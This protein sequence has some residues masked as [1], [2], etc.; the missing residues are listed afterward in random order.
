MTLFKPY[1]IEKSALDALA[2]KEGQ[3][4]F[5]TDTKEIYLDKNDTERILLGVED[6][7]GKLELKADKS[8]LDEIKISSSSEP[9]D[10][11][12]S[13]TVIAPIKDIKVKGN[14]AQEEQDFNFVS[15]NYNINIQSK[16]LLKI[17]TAINKTTHGITVSL[18]E[19]GGIKINGTVTSAF[20][21]DLALNLQL[22]GIY[23][24]S[25]YS[26]GFLSDNNACEFL[27]YN[28]ENISKLRAPGYRNQI[29]TKT[30]E[31]N[32]IINRFSI[33]FKQ[34][35]YLDAVF[36]FQLEKGEKATAFSKPVNGKQ[37]YQLN[38]KNIELNKIGDYSDYIYKKENKWIKHQVIKR[39]ILNSTAD[40]KLREE[41]GLI[42]TID[43]DINTFSLS[44]WFS[45]KYN[46]KN[47][48]VL[49]NCL[50]ENPKV[51]KWQQMF[52]QPEGIAFY[53]KEDAPIS[54]TIYI[55]IKK[56]SVEE[57][58]Q[59]IQE[60]Q[61]IVYF[62]LQE[63]IEEE[64]TDS[65]IINQLNILA[66]MQTY[67]GATAIE[68]IS[69]ENHLT[70]VLQIENYIDTINSRFE[71]EQQKKTYQ[72]TLSTNYLGNT[73]PYIQTVYVEGITNNDCIK[74]YPIYSEDIL[75]RN[76]EK[77]EYNKISFI[78]ADNNYIIITCDEKK[79]N[80]ILN[81]LLEV[82]K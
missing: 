77:E 59:W 50:I 11:Y 66:K 35:L 67:D 46:S 33:Y 14:T 3:L 82:A 6:L 40:W 16:N 7:E 13:K 45:Y 4:I 81:V 62:I 36:Y 61:P 27:L 55:N 47:N 75:I 43:P 68:V 76:I 70:P 79:P 39:V 49:C 52:D 57:L 69:T 12:I 5:C 26:T 32:D 56:N 51:D 60:N 19:D 20:N 2:I 38:L 30:I 9:I 24:V 63:P 10:G 22:D 41:D 1:K 74:M 53:Y 72:V 29:M 23:T 78:E 8:Y 44:N 80:R 54:R 37:E 18:L 73:A 31:Y 25:L 34:N 64:I 58:Q 42:N 17:P 48:Y 15:R 21:L 71:L 28:A 65:D